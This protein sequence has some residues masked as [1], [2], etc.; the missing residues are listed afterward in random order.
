MG[1]TDEEIAAATAA[2]AT[3]AT[4]MRTEAAQSVTGGTAGTDGAGG[5]DAG[6]GGSSAPATTDSRNAGEYELAIEHGST[7]LTVEAAAEADDVMFTDAMAGL[8]RGRTMLV[9]ESDPDMTTGDIVREI[10]IVGTDIEAPT[11]T[12]FGMH[13][14]LDTNPDTSNPPVNQSLT[15]NTGNVGMWSSSA[16]PSTSSTT[17][18]YEE[19][20]D[21]T[22]GVNEGAV[23]GMFNGAPGTFECVS[24]GCSLVTDADGD[25][26]TVNGTW[27]FTPDMGAMV[28]VPDDEYLS[29]GFWLSQT[30]DS[31]GAITYDEVETFAMAHGYDANTGTDIGEIDGTASYSGDSVGVYVMNV[32]DT[33]GGILSSTSGHFVADVSL[34]ASFGGGDV[35]QNDQFTIGGEIT[36]FVLS[37]GE[38][39]DWTVTLGLAD[40]SGGRVGGGEPGMSLPGSSHTNTFSGVATGDMQAAAGSYNGAFHG[41]AGDTVDHDGDTT[42]DAID[43]VAP[44]AVTGEFNANFTNGTVAGGFGATED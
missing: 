10:A 23:M 19:D 39:N 8:D 33:Q 22:M 32:T 18:A 26:A 6:L 28:D 41:L 1:P 34:D 2:A 21:T 38:E 4:A 7:T 37:G 11:P 20:D 12:A 13:H 40:L 24:S 44:G 15:V 25:L 36:G 27:R 5:A 43:D 17:Q 3:K 42:T 29:Y 14:T 30:E 9:L 16:F 35:R 31:D